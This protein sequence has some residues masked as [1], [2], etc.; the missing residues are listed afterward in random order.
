LKRYFDVLLDG[1]PSA[2]ALFAGSEEEAMRMAEAT[3][4]GKGK[5][6]TVL[7][8]VKPPEEDLVEKPA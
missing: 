7:D 2:Y 1:R 4:S 3:F 8:T 6:I 5:K